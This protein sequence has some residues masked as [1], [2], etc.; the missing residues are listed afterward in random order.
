MGDKVDWKE[1]QKWLKKSGATVRE[2]KPKGVDTGSKEFEVT[3][4]RFSNKKTTIVDALPTLGPISNNEAPEVK[5]EPYLVERRAVA[6]SAS[7]LGADPTPVLGPNW[8]SEFPREAEAL[9]E[10]VESGDDD[11]RRHRR[12]SLREPPGGTFEK[13]HEGNGEGERENG[14]GEVR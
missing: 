3:V 11:L 5:G 8:K 6:R 14:E 13:E 1:V 4:G 2:L 10:A 9:A 7:V 12:S